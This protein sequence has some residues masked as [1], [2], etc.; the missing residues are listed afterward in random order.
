MLSILQGLFPGVRFLVAARSPRVLKRISEDCGLFV[1]RGGTAN[2]DRLRSHCLCNGS[3]SDVLHTSVGIAIHASR[4]RRLFREFCRTLSR[5]SCATT[6]AILS[7]VGS[8]LNSSPRVI[9]YH[10]RLSFDHV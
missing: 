3:S 9:G 7:R 10:A 5:S 4:T 1:L 8:G 6:R 2:R